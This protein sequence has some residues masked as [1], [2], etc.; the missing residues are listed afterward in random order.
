MPYET[1][2]LKTIEYLAIPSVVGH[3]KLFL[4]YLEEDFLNL[5][6]TVTRHEGIL[7]VSGNHPESA[8]I[9]AHVDRHG[10]VSLG[11]GKYAYAAQYIKEKKYGEENNPSKKILDAISDRFEGETVYAYDPD[12]GDRLGEGII[13]NCDPCMENGDSIFFIDGME[14]MPVN[15][16][17]AYGRTAV[18]DGVILKGQIDNVVSIGVIYALFQNGFQGTALLSC[19]EEIGKSWIHITNWL[20]KK[21]IETK[22][23]IIIDTSPYRESAPVEANMI[24]LR[25]RDK[26]E[27]FNPI[28][29]QKI[30]Q[31]CTD[32]LMP[33]QVK[34]EYFLEMGLTIS[35]LGSTELGRIVEN[36]DGRWSGATIQIPTTEY[37]T[38]YETTSRGCIDSFYAILQNI[39]VTHPLIG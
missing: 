20:E 31:R 13:R 32:L 33:F 23:L 29:V 39:L 19:E 26:S 14:D 37:H 24:V 5:G 7:E 25:N 22:E 35:A 12:T 28:L 17:I 18:S 36:S 38:S 21:H 15:T 10:L 11:D 2:A 30:K 6:L 34:D 27:S 4:K 9:S 1:V 8:I 3:E 16:P